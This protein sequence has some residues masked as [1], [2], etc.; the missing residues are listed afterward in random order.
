MT[1]LSTADANDRTRSENPLKT[2]PNRSFIHCFQMSWPRKYFR[3][4]L[5]ATV[6]VGGWQAAGLAFE[7]FE[8]VV[9]V[10]AGEVYIVPAGLSHAIAPGS[11]GTLVIIDP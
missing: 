4:L 10:M 9:P 8:T 3:A 5:P 11:H 1:G 6:T 7:F 2:G